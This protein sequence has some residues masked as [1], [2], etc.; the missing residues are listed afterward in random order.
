MSNITNFQYEGQILALTEVIGNQR[1][2]IQSLR[3]QLSEAQK[4]LD[5]LGYSQANEKTQKP[6][7]TNDFIKG[8]F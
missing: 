8:G 5:K 6:F 2:E 3:I 7:N 1:L 4:Q